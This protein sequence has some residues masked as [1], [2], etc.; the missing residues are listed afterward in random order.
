[1]RHAHDRADRIALGLPRLLFH[2]PDGSHGRGSADPCMERIERPA[3][4][5]PGRPDGLIIHW[6][7]D[8]AAASE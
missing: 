8:G 4:C 5:H 3:G 1:M 2:A 7:N 6:A